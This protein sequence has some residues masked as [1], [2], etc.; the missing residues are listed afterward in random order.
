[1]FENFEN[2]FNEKFDLQEAVE[3]KNIEEKK[4]F[5]RPWTAQ[6]KDILLSTS[7]QHCGK[8]TPAGGG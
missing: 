6:F 7:L 1:M 8:A 4:E 3:F 5:N 2:Y